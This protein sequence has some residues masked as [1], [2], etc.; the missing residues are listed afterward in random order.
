MWSF[1][2][3]SESAFAPLYNTLVLPHLE[4]AAPACSPNLVA[5]ADCLEQI[6][7]LVTRLVKGFHRLPYGERPR[8]LG[9]HSLNRH[10]LRGYLIAAYNVFSGGLDLDPFF[11]PQVRPGFRGHPF[12]CQQGPSRRLRRKSSFS[13]RVVKYW[14]RLPTSIVTAPPINSFKRQLDSAW[15]ELVSEVP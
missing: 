14:N 13:I 8:R 10:R 2:E 4:Y 9:L 5:D 1:A 7:R 15:D 12:K 3:L 6:Q 11:N